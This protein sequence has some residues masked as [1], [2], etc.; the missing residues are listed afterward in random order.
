MTAEAMEWIGFIVVTTL[1]ASAFAADIPAA[2]AKEPASTDLVSLRPDFLAVWE[3]VVEGVMCR[4]DR[5]SN[6]VTRNFITL[7]QIRRKRTCCDNAAEEHEVGSKC[8]NITS[9]N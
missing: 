7:L 3:R 5:Q 9:R 2:R 6:Y 1:G 8:G 4:T